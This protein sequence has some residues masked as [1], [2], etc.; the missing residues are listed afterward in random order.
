MRSGAQARSPTYGAETSTATFS[1]VGLGHHGTAATHP[2]PPRRTTSPS[3]EARSVER[4]GRHALAALSATTKRRKLAASLPSR[5]ESSSSASSSSSSSSGGLPRTGTRSDFHAHA[6]D[7]LP[8]GHQ[9]I[10]SL[11]DTIAEIVSSSVASSLPESIQMHRPSPLTT[12]REASPASK[13][14]DRRLAVNQRAACRTAKRAAEAA[15][16]SASRVLVVPLVLV[17]CSLIHNSCKW[18]NTV[19]RILVDVPILHVQ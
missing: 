8:S 16:S 2:R 17:L 5:T 3:R 15:A 11:Q 6:L 10:R 9:R 7:R 18:R 14:D 13:R 1:N 12:P 4:P 19:K